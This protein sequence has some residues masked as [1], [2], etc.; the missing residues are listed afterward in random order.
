MPFEPLKPVEREERYVIQSTAVPGDVRP[1]S[2][3]VVFHPYLATQHSH[4]Y[5]PECTEDMTA[6]VTRWLWEGML[7]D[8]ARKQQA[9]HVVA[10]TE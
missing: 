1:C 5:G 9:V 7:P 10:E 6:D 2:V 4:V 8:A 3:L